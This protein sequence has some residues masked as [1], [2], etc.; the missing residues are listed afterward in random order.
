MITLFIYL[1]YFS[2]KFMIWL[3]VFPFKIV[4]WILSFFVPCQTETYS[5]PKRRKKYIDDKNDDFLMYLEVF[6]DTY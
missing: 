4:I 6:D 3:C 1:I 5:T 2:I